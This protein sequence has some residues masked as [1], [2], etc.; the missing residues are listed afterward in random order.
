LFIFFLTRQIKR[1]LVLRYQ[2]PSL[3]Q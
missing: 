3:H 1:Q 2:L